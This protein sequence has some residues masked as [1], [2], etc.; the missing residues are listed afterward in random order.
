MIGD[1]ADESPITNHQSRCVRSAVVTAAPSSAQQETLQGPECS[2]A[3]QFAEKKQMTI[4]GRA[5][6]CQ[7]AKAVGLRLQVGREWLR[8]RIRESSQTRML[9]LSVQSRPP[10]SPMCGQSTQLFSGERSIVSRP[11]LIANWAPLLNATSAALWGARPGALPKLAASPGPEA[12]LPEKDATSGAMGLQAW[13]IS[14]RT[15]TLVASSPGRT[16]SDGPRR[17]RRRPYAPGVLPAGRLLR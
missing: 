4:H 1:W 11:M 3:G 9:E 8:R 5:P 6:N 10:T 15:G 13:R 2:T 16:T 14:Q 17:S 7:T 12:L